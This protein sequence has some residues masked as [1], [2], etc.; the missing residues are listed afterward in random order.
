[1]PTPNIT[2]IV[3]KIILRNDILDNW[4]VSKIILEKGEPALEMDLTRMTAK[5]KIGDGLHTFNELPYSTVTPTDI[6]DMID[7]SIE[8]LEIEAAGISKVALASG[9]ENGTLKLIVNDTEYDNIAVTGLGT[10]AFTD[11]S[12]YATAEQGARAETA[13]VYKGS[14]DSLP[15]E[16]VK[17]GDTFTATKEFIIAADKSETSKEINVAIGD[18]LIVRQDGKWTVMPTGVADT[19][20]SLT[21]G[22]SA[23]VTGGATGSAEAANAGETMKIK[24]TELNTDYLVQGLNVIILHGGNASS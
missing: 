5:I 6:Q 8:R 13:M 18:K 22:I 1:M 24:I 14:V 12:A 20:K 17:V 19:A 21:K 4:Q 7:K 23:S 3:T 9:T 15:T 2:T 11:S 10:A 16:N